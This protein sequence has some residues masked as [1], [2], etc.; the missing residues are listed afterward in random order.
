MGWSYYRVSQ[1][2]KPV[3]Q[4]IP[5]LREG[6]LDK[7]SGTWLFSDAVDFA[8]L[9]TM[10]VNRE[11]AER[12]H[13]LATSLLHYSPEPRVIEPLIESAALLGR[14]DEVAY[15]LQRFRAA[16]PKDYAR[17]TKLNRALGG[18]LPQ[19]SSPR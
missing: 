8:R 7:V 14:D 16:Y 3:E 18:P 17:W 19:G 1:V 12:V 9:T 4:R 10:P 15:H 5:S 2:F 13:A 6:T 11:T